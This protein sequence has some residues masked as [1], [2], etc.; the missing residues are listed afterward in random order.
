MEIN[1]RKKTEQSNR[2]QSSLSEI[3]SISTSINVLKEFCKRM[4]RRM[5]S[6]REMEA[7]EN[8]NAK[9]S[10]KILG[11]DEPNIP[12]TENSFALLSRI[13]VFRLIKLTVLKRRIA[14]IMYKNILR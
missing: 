5:A 3:D 14:A 9:I 8:V 13:D 6:S 10:L 2:S 12:F 7:T 4:D 1:T 11:F